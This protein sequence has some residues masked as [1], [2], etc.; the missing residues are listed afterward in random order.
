MTKRDVSAA[1]A[2]GRICANCR[3]SWATT[4]RSPRSRPQMNTA[5]RVCNPNKARSPP[6][7]PPG[8]RPSE[9]DRPRGTRRARAKMP[10]AGCAEGPP[11]RRKGSPRTRRKKFGA[12]TERGSLKKKGSPHKK[13]WACPHSARNREKSSPP[14]PPPPSKPAFREKNIFHVGRPVCA[15]VTK[16]LIIV[17]LKLGS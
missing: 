5:R 4:W 7:P 8:R 3:Q 10:K 14:H 1:G 13:L 6:L 15:R 11:P 2:G 17:F 12:G 16:D 9:S